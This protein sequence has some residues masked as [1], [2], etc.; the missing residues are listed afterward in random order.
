MKPNVL[1]NQQEASM[2]RIHDLTT[3][4]DG[5]NVPG[6][7][8]YADRALVLRGTAFVSD[9]PIDEHLA[10]L[11]D[12]DVGANEVVRLDSERLVGDLA[13]REEARRLVVERAKGG[14]LLQFFSVTGHEERLLENLGLDWSHA[15]SAPL[16]VTRE[17]NDKAELR[18]LAATLGLAG[19]FPRFRV[20]RPSDAS[21]VYGMV[22]ALMNDGC[23]FVVLKRPDLASGDGMKLVERC[24]NWADHVDPYLAA[25][26]NA[27]EIIVEAG[28]EH[29][30]MSVQW[31][32]G[33]DGPSFACA[34]A[35]LIDESFTHCGNILASGELPDVTAVDV[36]EM[37]RMS[38]P[39][40]RHYWSRGFRGICG[41]DFLR[42]VRDGRRFM[43]ECN[44]RVT[45]TTYANG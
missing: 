28:Y 7:P 30:P 39:F 13:A 8:Y 17:A 16:A 22:G 37:R 45:A 36:A 3:G 26:A 25:H 32:I 20:C 35:Q 18:R 12:V 33:A 43:L 14:S 31:E 24:R 38:E 44:G 15:Y 10:Y 4:F 21:A 42:A 6:I 1:S 5:L 41:F 29:V 27:R 2:I 23:D 40:V 19:H 9:G 34:T 11:K